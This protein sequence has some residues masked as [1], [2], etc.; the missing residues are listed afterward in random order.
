[1]YE[2]YNPTILAIDVLK[3][4]R[5]LDDELFYLRNAPP[6]YSTVP[7]SMEKIPHPPGAQVP[8]NAMKVSVS[9]MSLLY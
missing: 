5:R 4:E 6:Q 7:F 9:F 2:I 8:I 1:M 3:L